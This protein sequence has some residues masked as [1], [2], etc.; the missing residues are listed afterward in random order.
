MHNGASRRGTARQVLHTDWD[1]SEAHTCC[2]ACCPFGVVLALEPCKLDVCRGV[3][4]SKN[5]R[6]GRGRGKLYT[7]ET[8]ELAQ[9]GIVCF[10][11][12]LVH[13]GSEY[14]DAAPHWRIHYGFHRPAGVCPVCRRHGPSADTTT[15]YGF[16]TTTPKDLHECGYVSAQ[17]CLRRRLVSPDW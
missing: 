6:G 5:R 11:G 17:G 4:L 13:G 7:R 3:V 2:M 8:I 1:W 14:K 12:F 9:G 10:H 15:E 16:T